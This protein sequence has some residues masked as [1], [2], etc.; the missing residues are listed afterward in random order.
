M[1]REAN[2]PILLC[3]NQNRLPLPS[4]VSLEA[5]RHLDRNAEFAYR[6]T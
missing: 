3:T 6:E 2:V 1:R 5:L 4:L